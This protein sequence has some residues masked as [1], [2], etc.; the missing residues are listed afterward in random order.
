MPVAYKHIDL[1]YSMDGHIYRIGPLCWISGNVDTIGKTVPSGQ[2]TLL[3]TWPEG[4]RPTGEDARAQ[5]AGAFSFER[6]KAGMIWEVQEDGRI[7][8]YCD[9][10]LAHG[11]SS[12]VKLVGMWYTNDPWPTS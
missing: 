12:N 9:A 1:G 4:F 11:N 5:I 6:T 3:E 7:K 2:H 10:D 8:F